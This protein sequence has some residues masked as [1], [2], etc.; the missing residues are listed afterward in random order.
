MEECSRPCELAMGRKKREKW[1]R[2]RNCEV[3]VW[4]WL[5]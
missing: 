4:R 5:F 1:R 3:A 2:K